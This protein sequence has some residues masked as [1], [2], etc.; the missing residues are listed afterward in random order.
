MGSLIFPVSMG[1]DGEPLNSREA[2][3]AE[4]SITA[5]DAV[6]ADPDANPEDAIAE[7]DEWTTGESDPYLIAYFPLSLGVLLPVIGTALG[8]RAV[9]RRSSAKTVNRTMYV[10]LFGTLLNAQ[11]LLVFLP[12]VIALAVAAFQVRKAEVAAGSAAAA[13]EVDA[14]L[15]VA[16]P[17]T[18]ADAEVVDV[19]ESADAST[20]DPGDDE[21]RG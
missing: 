13:S 18:S 21:P 14:D 20:A 11:L 3:V 1:R 2:L 4:W 9:L 10:T 16:A 8:L 5:L 7:V 19:H 12:A 6:Q 17:S 15:D